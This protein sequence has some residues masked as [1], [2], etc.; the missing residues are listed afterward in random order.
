[1]RR[2]LTLAA[3]LVLPFLSGC[4]GHCWHNFWCKP[5]LF[6]G[7]GGGWCGAAGTGCA[8]CYGGPGPMGMP[9]GVPNSPMPMYPTSAPPTMPAAPAPTI[10]KLTSTRQVPTRVLR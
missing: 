4:C 2:T 6:S 10:E 3:F 8:S 5:C 9:P 1:M 7:C